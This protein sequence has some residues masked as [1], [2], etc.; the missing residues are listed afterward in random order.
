M[1]KFFIIFVIVCFSSTSYSQNNFK[2]FSIDVFAG[3]NVFYGDIPTKNSSS[4]SS[5]L[6]WHLTSA[7]NVNA[8][9]SYC[10]L[11][12]FN[13]KDNSYFNNNIIKTML[14]GELYFF[15]FF[16]V[17]G[18]SKFVQPYAGI[19]IGGIKSN[20]V[21]AAIL[22]NESTKLYK[23]WTFSYE[24][25][26]G[27]K[28]KLIN[29]LDINAK[30]VIVLS[31]TDMLD[32]YKPVVPANRFNDSYIELSLGITFHFLKQNKIPIIWDNNSSPLFFKNNS[33]DNDNEIEYSN[34]Y[35]I[36]TRIKEL[37]SKKY[38]L[39]NSSKQK[40]ES[41][42]KDLDEDYDEDEIYKCAKKF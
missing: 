38:E 24:Y 21:S 33:N 11:K 2:N 20:V 8:E 22:K 13:E 29:F 9:F 39:L 30:T 7:L 4:F 42:S 5:K 28:V 19:N 3:M 37:Q 26:A 12:G 32:N 27:L 35:S 15:N 14:G 17:K 34:V 25:V 1:K 23:D 36:D 6:N 40:K 41:D 31:R 10:L 16:Q 18:I